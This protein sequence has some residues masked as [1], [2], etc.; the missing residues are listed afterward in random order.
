VPAA[1]RSPLTAVEEATPSE[2]RTRGQSGS[3]KKWEYE[4]LGNVK[5]GAPESG[6]KRH[7]M[8]IFLMQQNNWVPSYSQGLLFFIFSFLTSVANFKDLSLELRFFAQSEKFEDFSKDF[9]YFS[10]DF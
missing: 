3:A 8:A 5:W 1:L 2:W 7:K 4:T 10:E 6:V 9:F